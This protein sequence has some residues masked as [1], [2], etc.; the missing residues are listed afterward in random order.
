MTQA[1][2]VRAEAPDQAAALN[3]GLLAD[4][5]GPRVRIIWNLLSADMAKALAPFGLRT[6][7]F[8]AL[9]LI[10][11]N[12]GCSQNQL[13]QGL[14]MDKSAV[15][16]IVDEL[17]RRDLATRVRHPEDRRFHALKLTAKGKALLQRMSEPA[18]Q[19]GQPIRDALSPREMQQLLSLL[20]R[21]CRALER[22]A[23]PAKAAAVG[24]RRRQP[25]RSVHT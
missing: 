20:D 4:F 14:G 5:V 2:P 1:D 17:E 11:A 24:A 3:L 18:S 8:S 12:P 21:A 15:V 22:P 10:A 23:P 7:A 16:A 6:G 19:P 9:A 25:E 13:A